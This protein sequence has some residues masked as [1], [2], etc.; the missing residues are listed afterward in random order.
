M[1][2]RLES[3]NFMNLWG[4]RNAKALKTPA[5]GTVPTSL[6]TS[7]HIMYHACMLTDQG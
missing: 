3:L 2:I 4:P 1:I 5:A 6:R 7:G